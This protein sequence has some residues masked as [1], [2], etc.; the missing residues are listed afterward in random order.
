M[1]TKLDIMSGVDSDVYA[2]SAYSDYMMHLSGKFVFSDESLSVMRDVLSVRWRSLSSDV[3]AYR[4]V[5][6]SASRVT[7]QL[8]GFCGSWL[9]IFGPVLGQEDHHRPYF[10]SFLSCFDEL[11]SGVDIEKS[12]IS[13]M[14]WPDSSRVNSAHVIANLSYRASRFFTCEPTIHGHGLKQLRDDS[15]QLAFDAQRPMQWVH[16]TFQEMFFRHFSEPPPLP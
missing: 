13:K 2:G 10:E 14:I 4:I 8:A 7:R 15:V 1:A 3:Y 16:D 5:S 12:S 11:A 6:L 9:R